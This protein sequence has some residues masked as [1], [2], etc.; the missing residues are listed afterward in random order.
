MKPPSF[1]FVIAL[2]D[3]RAHRLGLSVKIEDVVS[4]LA[5]PAGL[6]VAPER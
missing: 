1:V 4:H 2:G 6:F 3:A 5:S